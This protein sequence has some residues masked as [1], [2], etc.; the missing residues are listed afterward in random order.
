[1]GNII[2]N[3]NF[4]E[5]K[6]REYEKLDMIVFEQGFELAHQLFPAGG[7]CLEFG[8]GNGQSFSYMA[9][10]IYDEYKKTSLVGFDS[11]KGLPVETKGVWYPNRHAQGLF[12]FEKN[13]ILEKMLSILNSNVG[14]QIKLVDGFFENSLT[15]SLRNELANLIFVNI[16]VDI[17]KSTQQVL[18]F[19]TP[20]LQENTLLY[21]DD[22]KDPD[23]VTLMGTSIEWGEHLAWRQWSE[24]HPEIKSEVITVSYANQP[25]IRIVK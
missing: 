15:E 3:R 1:M 21:F 10:R 5:D 4:I 23:D 24:K 17:H 13:N 8:V 12:R 7:T 25:L 22:W 2:I 18:N 16:D 19:I 14:K 20:L 6:I 11:W 9:Q